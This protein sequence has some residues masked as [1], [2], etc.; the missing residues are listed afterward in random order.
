MDQERG[1][2][3]VIDENDAVFGDLPAALEAPT[4]VVNL[5]GMSGE[6]LSRQ[7][8]DAMQANRDAHLAL[9]ACMPHGRDFQTH[10]DPEATQKARRAHQRAIEANAT[11]FNYLS[12]RVAALAD[13]G[14]YAGVK[15]T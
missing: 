13:Q 8:H 5:N 1:G 6:E 11:I 12:E 10:D 14:Y 3:G 15:R 4:P 7:W 9:V 2:G